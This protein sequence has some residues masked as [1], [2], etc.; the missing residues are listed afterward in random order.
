MIFIIT[1]P[2]TVG[3]SV[4]LVA[5]IFASDS[6]FPLPLKMWIPVEI[7]KTNY[8]YIFLILSIRAF[9]T[10]LV[11]LANDL[12]FLGFSLRAAH[13]IALLVM[14]LKRIPEILKSSGKSLN[15]QSRRKLEKNLICIS[16]QHLEDIHE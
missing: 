14:R 11:T 16:A 6:E 7:N 4:F 8:P 13:Q 5:P 3:V 1:P 12:L 2:G 10:G 15:S 9:F